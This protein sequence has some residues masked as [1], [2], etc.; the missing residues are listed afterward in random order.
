[1]TDHGLWSS[2][3]HDPSANKQEN[4]FKQKLAKIGSS[5]LQV[6]GSLA[7]ALTGRLP[8]VINNSADEVFGP[9]FGRAGSSVPRNV[10]SFVKVKAGESGYVMVADLPKEIDS[11]DAPGTEEL[12][13]VA[14]SLTDVEVMELILFGTSDE[15]QEALPLM[16]AQQ[17]AMVGRTTRSQNEKP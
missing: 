10:H 11:T 6:A 5:G 1:M 15:I 4:R 8:V 7:G 17:R 12:K 14:T 2:K 9:T 3:P 16:S 13:T